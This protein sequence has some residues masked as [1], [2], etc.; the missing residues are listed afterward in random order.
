[1]Y[2]LFVHVLIPDVVLKSFRNVAWLL[3]AGWG[4]SSYAAECWTDSDISILEETYASAVI[5]VW[6]PRMA[7][8]LLHADDVAEQARAAGL[9]FIPV[10]DSRVPEEEWRGALKA[11]ETSRLSKLKYL[12]V[13]QRS[14]SLCADRLTDLDAYQHFPSVFMVHSGQMQAF[15]WTGAMNQDIWARAFYTG[16]AHQLPQVIADQPVSKPNPA[17]QSVVMANAPPTAA[18]LNAAAVKTQVGESCIAANQFIALPPDLAGRGDDQTVALGA[19][20]RISPDGRFVLRSFSGKQL[21]AV[22]LIELPGPSVQQNHSDGKVVAITQTPLSNEAFPVQGSWRYIVDTNGQH[23]SF[24]NL[25]ARQM[26]ASP[27]F[28][29]GMSG[30]YAAAAEVA[31]TYP[32]KALGPIQI[33][34]LSWPNADSASETVGEGMLTSR[35]IVVDPQK[36]HLLA[37][38]GR[39][40]LCL[41]RLGIDG[42]LYSLPMISVDG[43]YFAAL[44]QQPINSIPTMRVFGFGEDGRQCAPRQ[45][46]TS[47]S[48]KVTFG[49]TPDIS[50]ANR[51]LADLV[52]EYRGQTWWYASLAAK[53][54]NIAPWDEPS[55]DAKTSYR[56]KIIA[57]AFPGMT[58]DGR[59]IYAATWQFCRNNACIDQAGYVVSDPYQSNAFQQHLIASTAKHDVFKIGSQCISPE[60]VL[61]E[62]SDFAK[63]HGIAVQ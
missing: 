33:R 22:S 30:F 27:V 29:G 39:V 8:S 15:K 63:F 53:A 44:P 58:R 25:L 10:V 34:S 46:F 57:S 9:R 36:N 40:N 26:Q 17:N 1:M 52:Y 18:M 50:N 47:P 38:S 59:V 43:Q 14:T 32:A 37:D 23:Y 4:S 6:S 16:L 61:R 35:T 49:F 31:S 41:N 11:A 42:S 13:L 45:Q 28:K 19:Y 5:Y 24:S 56:Q 51:Q 60:T 21:S 2:W 54:F 55:A 12:S 3:I 20:E 62:R 7:L 48:G